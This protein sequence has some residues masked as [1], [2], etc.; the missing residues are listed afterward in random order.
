M[1][2]GSV[3]FAFHEISLDD[4]RVANAGKTP[5]SLVEWCYAENK[6]QTIPAPAACG[7]AGQAAH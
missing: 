1:S 4:L 2:D 5:D 3:E 6:E 7:V